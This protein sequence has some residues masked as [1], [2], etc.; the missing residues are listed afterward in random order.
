MS[1]TKALRKGKS[2]TTGR[3]LTMRLSDAGLRRRQT[4]ALYLN[5]RLPPRLN[6]DATRDRSNRLLAVKC[7]HANNLAACACAHCYDDRLVTEISID[8]VERKALQRHSV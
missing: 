3:P 2:L 1:A 4:K 8:E 5:H 6:K 7:D